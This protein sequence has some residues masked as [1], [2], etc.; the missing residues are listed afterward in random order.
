MI[1]VIYYLVP[2]YV[3]ITGT[4]ILVRVIGQKSMFQDYEF[5][6]KDIILNPGTYIIINVCNVSVFYTYLIRISSYRIN[7][8]ILNR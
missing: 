7:V 3:V 8:Q 6:R 2:T 1:D 4:Y 5:S